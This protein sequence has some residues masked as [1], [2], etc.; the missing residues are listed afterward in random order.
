VDV[1]R[2][3]LFGEFFFDVGDTSGVGFVYGE[4][5]YRVVCYRSAGL[6]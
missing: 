5:V 2:V 1:E 3:V 6:V 4:V